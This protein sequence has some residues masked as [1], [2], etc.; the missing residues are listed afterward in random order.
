MIT[1]YGITQCATV[2][3]AKNWLDNNKMPYVFV[4]FK[5]IPIAPT[6]IFIWL[7]KLGS[8]KLINRQGLT[9]RN[10]SDT[11]KQSINNEE[12]TIALLVKKPTLMKRPILE[13]Q[14]KLL[15]GFD[16]TQYQELFR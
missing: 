11:D 1:L 5:K 12:E 9:W 4:D 16:L 14:E 3:R 13:H 2:Q 6:K 7:N 10:L 15:C 8:Q